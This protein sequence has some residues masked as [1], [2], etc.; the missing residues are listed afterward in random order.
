MSVVQNEAR[1]AAACR[2]FWSD[3]PLNVAYREVV[4]H[5]PF[6]LRE[7]IAFVL[8]M[9]AKQFAEIMHLTSPLL[10]QSTGPSSARPAMPSG[11]V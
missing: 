6:T 9:P 10:D 1:R 2:A 7:F 11:Q 3:A 4:D 5:R 8:A